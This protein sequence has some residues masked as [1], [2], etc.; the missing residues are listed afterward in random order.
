M[1]EENMREYLEEVLS[2][3]HSDVA[4]KRKNGKQPI[5]SAA[6]IRIYKILSNLSLHRRIEMGAKCGISTQLT[7][8]NVMTKQFLAYRQL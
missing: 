5:S 2:E 4:E 7:M 1:K 3:I 6:T 8:R